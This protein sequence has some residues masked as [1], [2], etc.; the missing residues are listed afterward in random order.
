MDVHRVSWLGLKGE[1][2]KD[3]FVAGFS[4][5]GGTQLESQQISREVIRNQ[6][7]TH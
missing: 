6:A 3:A 1:H 4:S 7:I 2:Q 5:R